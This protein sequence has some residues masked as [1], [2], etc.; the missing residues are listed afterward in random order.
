MPSSLPKPNLEH[1]GTLPLVYEEDEE[2]TT[3]TTISIAS[4]VT[5][6]E[7]PVDE[8]LVSARNNYN[9]P[10]YNYHQL[11]NHQ[12]DKDTDGKP[13]VV[14]DDDQEHEHVTLTSIPAA[15]AP[16]PAQFPQR[17]INVV[18]RSRPGGRAGTLRN[19]FLGG[20]STTGYLRTRGTNRRS[21]L[22]HPLDRTRNSGSGIHSTPAPV[23]VM[24]MVVAAG[25]GQQSV[26]TTHMGTTHMATH[27]TADTERERSGLEL[28]GSRLTTPQ[29][30]K[31]RR[32]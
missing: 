19:G 18:V 2:R 6:P 3:R 27:L 21:T 20:S 22:M 4:S 24:N 26:A 32:K 10:S 5:L 15:K 30:L 13:E 31:T 17:S 16:P 9:K 28:T 1:Q 23:P 11:D 14:Q 8:D 25:G 12:H 7:L 29:Y